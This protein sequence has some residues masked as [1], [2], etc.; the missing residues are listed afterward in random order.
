MR[1]LNYGG[2]TDKLNVSLLTLN[3]ISTEYGGCSTTWNTS[4]QDANFLNLFISVRR[5]TCFRRFSVH[6]QELKTAHTASDQ[7]LTLYVQICAPDDGRKTRLKHVQR[8]T[9]INCETLH[10][11]GC[12]LQIY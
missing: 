5:S 6:H 8:F 11:V 3:R 1:I 9:E 10:L 7:Y 2:F 4:Q 12:T